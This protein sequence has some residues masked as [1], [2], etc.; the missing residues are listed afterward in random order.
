MHFYNGAGQG[1]LR[2]LTDGPGASGT[3]GWTLQKVTFT[4]PPNATHMSIMLRSSSNSGT[5]WFDDV[6]LKT[7]SGQT[8]QQ[9]DF[10]SGPDGY[11]PERGP[12]QC[13][14]YDHGVG[15]LQPGSLAVHGT[16][17]YNG[18]SGPSVAIVPGK[19]YVLSAWVQLTMATG[20]TYISA[21]FFRDTVEPKEALRS[22]MAP[23]VAFGLKHNVPVWVGE[24]GCAASSSGGAQDQWVNICI[25]LFEEYGFDWT[26]WNFK[27]TTDPSSMALQAEHKDGSN[28]PINYALLT[29]LRSGWSHNIMP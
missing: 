8:L 24:F 19:S 15:H 11:A 9:S 27:E 21:A 28:F 6:S 13:M 7:A 23:A 3:R 1:W 14:S 29:D 26:Y 18:W 4:A 25:S 10:D 5:A 16:V 2:N 20:D 17:D 22:Y 12:A